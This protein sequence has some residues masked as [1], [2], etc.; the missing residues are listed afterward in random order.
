MATTISGTLEEA[1][2][3][4]VIPVPFLLFISVCFYFQH[5]F[6]PYIF[7]W[8]LQYFKFFESKYWSHTILVPLFIFIAPTAT[9]FSEFLFF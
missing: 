9:H 5:H 2:G 6:S 3:H 4:E 8:F 7:E 1:T